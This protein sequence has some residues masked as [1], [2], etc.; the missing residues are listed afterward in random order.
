MYYLRAMASIILEQT[1]LIPKIRGAY[2]AFDKDPQKSV[3]SCRVRMTGL[4]ENWQRFES[5]HHQIFASKDLEALMKDQPY[6]SDKVFDQVDEQHLVNLTL[7]QTYLDSHT[8][9]EDRA[10]E[11]TSNNIVVHQQSENL[12]R[13]PRL[14]LPDFNGDFRE[15]ESFR[16]VFYSSV[17]S[18]PNIPN[19]TKLRHLRAADLVSSYALTEENF[20]IVW[21]KLTER[22]ENKKRL[23]N[24]HVAA[25]F[26]LA[27]MTKTSAVELKRILVGLTTPLSALKVLGR[28]VDSWDDLLIFRIL[29][30]FDNETKR[31]WELYLCN[32]SLSARST[33]LTSQDAS[34]STADTQQNQVLTNF[35]S[36]PPN[37]DLLI[38]FMEAQI[39][40]LESIEENTPTTSISN[41]NSDK[42]K[43]NNVATQ[44]AIKVFHTQL[45]S[46]NNSKLEC[47]MCKA[48]H[49]LQ[50]CN[51]YKQLT[52]AKRYEFIKSIHTCCNCLGNHSFFNCTSKELCNICNKKHH[53]SL[54]D[55]N[56][57][58]KFQ[59][60]QD[61]NTANQ[62]SDQVTK[63]DN[64]NSNQV[65]DNESDNNFD[66]AQASQLPL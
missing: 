45:K 15:W 40:I 58:T 60:P 7:F 21:S 31:Q 44:P 12:E 33:Q 2:E 9:S 63:N 27:P 38:Q 3:A 34:N 48:N 25:I 36:N 23:V 66:S 28:P 43:N 1:S 6:F 29:S 10:R 64:S 62:N 65:T 47:L 13:L 50:N 26:N 24:A 61:S 41:S 46:N 8:S 51:S 4:I 53:T 16:D 55:D 56:Y 30:L 59:K 18:K 14:D 54:H 49:K 19:I 35:I 52:P 17:V 57:L 20:L 32:V 37:L 42:F 11:Q 39:G 5:N 22:F